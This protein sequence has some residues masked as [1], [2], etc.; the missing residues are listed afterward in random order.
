MWSFVGSKQNK[1]WIW[2][3]LDADSREIGGGFGGVSGVIRAY[4]G[5]PGGRRMMLLPDRSVMWRMAFDGAA[6]PQFRARLVTR[7]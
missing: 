7:A 5:V 2:L 6:F 3:A 4:L 1:Q